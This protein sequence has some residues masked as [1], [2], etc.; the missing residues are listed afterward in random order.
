M[1]HALDLPSAPPLPP[2]STGE[3]A[4]TPTSTS[5][6]S[7]TNLISRNSTIRAS[8]TQ[9]NGSTA[10]GTSIAHA[11]PVAS[12]S[13][14]LSSSAGLATMTSTNDGQIALTLLP[15]PPLPSDLAQ[16]L[17]ATSPL[18]PDQKRVLFTAVYLRAASSGNSDLLEWLLSLPHDPRLSSAENAANA[19]RF[20]LSRA[21]KRESQLSLARGGLTSLEVNGKSA[22]E[23]IDDDLPDW[24]ARKWVDLDGQDEEGNPALVLAVAFGHAEAVRILV[25]SGA[26]VNEADR[27]GW[28]ALH[29]AVQNNDVPIASYLLNHRASPLLASRRGLTARDLVRPG[30]EGLAMR[31]VLSSA[32]EAAIERERAMRRAAG[33]AASAT[34][35]TNGKGKEKAGEVSAG[36]GTIDGL[37]RSTS[38]LSLAALSEVDASS[39]SW[40]EAEGDRE[41]ERAEEKERQAVERR[42]W[43]LAVDSAEVLQLNLALLGVRDPQA[44]S[45][46]DPPGRAEEDEDDEPEPTTSTPFIWDRCEPDQMIVFSLFD[47]PMLLDVVVSFV[48]P[49]HTRKLRY[50]PANVIFLAARYAHYLGGTE[51][52]DELM[53]GALERIENNIHRQ[54]DDMAG[55]AFWLSNCL[56]ILYYLRTEPNLAVATSD[57]QAH[58]ADLINEIFVFIIRDA[59]RRIDRVLEASILE[60]EPLPGFEDV[61]FEDEWASTRFVKKLTG[62]A[63]RNTGMR[64]STSAMS[65]FSDSGSVSSADGIGG[66]GGPGSPG[67]QRT[68]TV[69]QTPKDVTDLLSATL[70]VMQLYEIP[71]VIIVQAFSQLFYWLACEIFNRLLTQRKYLC[72]SRA[73]QIRLNASNLEDWARA[74]HLSTKMVAVHFAPLNHLLQWL[75][76]LSSESSIDG[77]ISTVD[78][79]RGLNPPQLRRAVREYRYEVDETKMD[80]DCVEYLAQ[81]EKQWERQQLQRRAA[82]A[83]ETSNASVSEGASQGVGTAEAAGPHL[84]TVHAIDAVA[85]DPA[86]LA[87]YAP[88]K[89]P[90]SLGELL[91]SRHMLPFA[92]P[93]STDQLVRLDASAAFGPFAGVTPSPSR[94]T[95]TNGQRTPRSSNTGFSLPSSPAVRTDGLAPPVPIIDASTGSGS[96]TSSPETLVPAERH[97][98][99]L[100]DDFFAV[101]DTARKRAGRGNIPAVSATLLA[102]ADL[103]DAFKTPRLGSVDSPDAGE[104][105]WWSGGGSDLRNSG[106]SPNARSGGDSGNAARD[107]RRSMSLSSGAGPDPDT[108]YESVGSIEDTPKPSFAFRF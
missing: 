32:W 36:G 92:L 82:G 95:S 55:C 84:E 72:R 93:T 89:L 44:K 87:T 85:Q 21:Q 19:K 96:P 73:M 13:S 33:E 86:R 79:L 12:G 75:Q 18:S 59:E 20:S 74:N 16:Y 24:V 7:W 35:A 51:L 2:A 23:G 63:K 40:E 100:P 45:G 39:T 1:A 69:G 105:L 97:V 103:D 25:E 64:A 56:L 68:T 83:E 57:Y 3:V 108:S 78:T 8:H 27:A 90:D 10:A 62:R 48:R 17:A 46:R 88:P 14:S 102:Q 22:A 28:S 31:E 80:E 76:C 26:H 30:S 65:L 77:L 99:H 15:N 38:R 47:L 53:F 91:N 101:L 61:A 81:V 70:F 106:M 37:V 34:A 42:T 11:R 9:A 5:N 104:G 54:P 6:S 71:P 98:P 52:L 58:L 41:R 4:S 107:H 43:Q 49:I 29:W 67:R 66:G 94:D 50:I 60:H